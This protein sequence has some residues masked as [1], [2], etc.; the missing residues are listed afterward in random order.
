MELKLEV[1]VEPLEDERFSLDI[2]TDEENFAVSEVIESLDEVGD[3][4]TE[5]LYDSLELEED[6]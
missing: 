5:L 4:I 2:H 1:Y 6:L 3:I